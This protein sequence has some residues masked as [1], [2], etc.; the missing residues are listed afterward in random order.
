MRAS[1]SART[2]LNACVLSRRF[3]D[4]AEKPRQRLLLDQYLAKIN[5]SLNACQAL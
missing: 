1:R 4:V 2:H 3:R 5:R